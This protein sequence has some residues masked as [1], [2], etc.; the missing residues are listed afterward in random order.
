MIWMEFHRG[1][2][3]GGAPTNVFLNQGVT[4]LV[5][6]HMQPPIRGLTIEGTVVKPEGGSSSSL[7]FTQNAPSFTDREAVYRADFVP[8]NEGAYKVDLTVKKDDE[9]RPFQLSGSFYCK[10]QN[11]P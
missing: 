10:W 6:V 4:I 7:D 1:D 5:E 9:Y 8:L 3:A 11:S 2:A